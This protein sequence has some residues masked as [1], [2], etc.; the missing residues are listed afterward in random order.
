MKL[1]TLIS[2]YDF[3]VLDEAIQRVDWNQ[4]KTI[5][6]PERRK[7]QRLANQI[8]LQESYQSEKGNRYE[9]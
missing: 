5:H 6:L 9:S 2:D 4:V 1:E 3:I 7:K 8:V